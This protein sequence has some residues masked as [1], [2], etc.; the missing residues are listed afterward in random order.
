MQQSLH[1]TDPVAAL[2][3]IGEKKAAAFAR[4]GV[5]IIGDLLRFYPR[6][7]DDRRQ[8][9]TIQTLS[10][11]HPCRFVG[12]IASEPVLSR[13]RSSKTILK[14]RVVDETGS[15][16]ISFFNMPYRRGMFRVGQMVQFYGRA[17]LDEYGLSM[18]SPEFES[19]SGDEPPP[20]YIVPVYPLTDGLTNKAVISAVR[21]ALD[22]CGK[23]AT[24]PLPG[25]LLA[26]HGL[27]PISQALENIHAPVSDDM[28]TEARRRLIFE[29]LFL[30]TLGLSLL[31]NRRTSLCGIPCPRR[32]DTALRS[33]LPFA[34]TAAQERVIADVLADLGSGRL[35]NRLIQ[36]DV[37]SGKTLVAAF[38]AY[39]VIANGHQAALMAPTEILAAQ[40][41]ATFE[42]L[43]APLGIQVTL[44][45]G[46]MKV[47]QR[48]E[49]E[50][51]IA[52]GGAQMVIGTH[53]L[54]SRCVDF[55]SLGLVVCDEQ[56]R[57][58]VR[59]RAALT[60]KGLHPHLLVMSATPIPRTLALILYGDLDLS[61]IDELPPGRQTVDT[62]LVGSSMR[63]RIEAFVRKQAAE[64][65]QTYIV[66]P[67][68]DDTDNASLT[69]VTAYA[70]SLAKDVFAD[71]HTACLH[72]RM[73]SN[74]K[75]A[76]MDAFVRGE[77]DVLISTTVVEVGVDNPNATLM[78]IENAERF[79]LSQLHQL[80]G[81]VG[82]GSA[83]S[84]CILACGQGGKAV[85]ER[86]EILCRSSD[87]Y[88]IA[89]H[90]LEIR[91]PGAFFGEA[92]HGLP[93]LRMA[94]LTAD[95]PLLQEAQ[96]SA[97]QLLAEDPQ[98]DAP[99]HAQLRASVYALFDAEA[100]NTFN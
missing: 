64:G 27:M 88:E 5:R 96:A 24:E 83:K 22:A 28:L 72:G 1:L 39:Q 15:I 66:C 65:H 16:R 75:E 73:K 18:V 32:P 11:E 21:S 37:G 40:H 25:S 31:K 85:K 4:L 78:V 69:S 17:V 62:F 53:A 84:Y 94:N 79:G 92:Q 41:F 36:G 29:E 14:F 49:A 59:Q 7:Y 74:E 46:R 50:T 9:Y 42:K 82:R 54:L 52:S 90:D 20:G 57:F 99:Q 86:L 56:Q 48:R 71:L 67:L 76:V 12:L 23:D 10:L 51:A 6:T 89:Q 38:A 30:L 93:T 47:A 100:G 95:M 58:G 3:G 45:T 97:K 68:I 55:L 2:R 87:G 98:L 60:A 13:L 35:M 8:L 19:V 80:R 63:A 43:F 91:G 33:E 26:A 81:R 34:L 61:V 70:E 44:L 77:I